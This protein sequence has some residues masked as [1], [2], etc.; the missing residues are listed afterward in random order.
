MIHAGRD[1]LT[2]RD[3]KRVRLEKENSFATEEQLDVFEGIET[4]TEARVIV[5]QNIAI[6]IGTNLWAVRKAEIIAYEN[7]TNIDDELI[8]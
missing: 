6:K 2:I 5:N 1:R 4:F 7:E 3:L 8:N